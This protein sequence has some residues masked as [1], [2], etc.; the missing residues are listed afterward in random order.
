MVIH[1]R[2]PAHPALASRAGR[3]GEF[4]ALPPDSFIVQP[5][6]EQK[7][8]AKERGEMAQAAICMLTDHDQKLL[9]L[10]RQE[11][12]VKEIAEEMRIKNRSVSREINAVIKRLQEIIRKERAI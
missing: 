10:W 4:G 7:L 1:D 11:W 9:G 6:Q 2:K 12:S 5:D 3:D 8:L